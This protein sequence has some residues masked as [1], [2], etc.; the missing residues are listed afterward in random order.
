MYTGSFWILHNPVGIAPLYASGLRHRYQSRACLYSPFPGRGLGEPGTQTV[1]VVKGVRLLKFILAFRCYRERTW[2]VPVGCALIPKGQSQRKYSLV[3]R[4]QC[5]GLR[6]EGDFGI[7][8]GPFPGGLG[9]GARP[10]MGG[11]K[12]SLKNLPA[13]ERG[14]E[15]SIVRM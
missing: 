7:L 14:L 8:L 1:V 12:G 10:K 11:A 13:L 6:A 2:R 9:G 3:R 4:E 5:A 15:S